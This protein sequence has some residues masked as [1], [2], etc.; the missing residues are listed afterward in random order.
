MKEYLFRVNFK[1]KK[2]T[3]KSYLD[4]WAPNATVAL[5][6]L[7]YVVGADAEYELVG[8]NPVIENGKQM[9]REKEA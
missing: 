5:K 2:T 9:E 4:I 1:S 8:V 6:R 3:F 7:C